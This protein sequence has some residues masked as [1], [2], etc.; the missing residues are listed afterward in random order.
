MPCTI[1]IKD[2]NTILGDEDGDKNDDDQDVVFIDTSGTS[3]EPTPNL[4]LLR[5]R[6]LLVFTGLAISCILKNRKI[7]SENRNLSE[8]SIPLYNTNQ[9]L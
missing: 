4:N 7:T 8:D 1:L 6:P 3:V 5:I 2:S 9:R